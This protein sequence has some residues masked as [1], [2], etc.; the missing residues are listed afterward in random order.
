MKA[1]EVCG[2]EHSEHQAHRFPKS[3][4]QDDLTPVRQPGLTV[5]QS[6]LTACTHC[7]GHQQRILELE[8]ELT[9]LRRRP[10]DKR[11][12]QR[13]YMRRRRAKARG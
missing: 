3:V 8:A 4:R 12:Y 5:R 6:T 9:R 1:C 2:S 13:E 11:A 7:Q 10:F